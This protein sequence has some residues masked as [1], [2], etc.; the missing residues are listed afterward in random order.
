MLEKTL[1]SSLDCKE[2]QW[3]HPKGSQSW[4]LIGR[5]DDEDE[6]PTLWSPDA[7]N[8]LI[9]KDP[10]AWE[11]WGQEDKGMTEGEMA[12]CHHW[13]NEHEFEW[14]PRIGDGHE[15]LAF[16]SLWGHRI[17]HDW[18]TELNWSLI[19]Q[20]C[21]KL[22]MWQ[23]KIHIIHRNMYK[24]EIW[25]LIH[26]IMYL[27]KEKVCALF[28]LYLLISCEYFFWSLSKMYLA[29]G[30]GRDYQCDCQEQSNYLKCHLLF[31]WG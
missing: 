30:K 23:T 31:I 29:E 28:L 16:C 14:A 15:S 17:R 24:W 6:A 13:L 5:T 12:G 20:Y 7:K 27:H 19:V 22:K 8:C 21:N 9:G 10:D 26:S 11:D 25:I 1:E 2:I 18:A 4:I 3:V